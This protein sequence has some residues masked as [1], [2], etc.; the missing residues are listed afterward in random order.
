[1]ELARKTARLDDGVRREPVQ[2]SG[3][4]LVPQAGGGVR[5][6]YLPD[7]GGVQG[8]AAPSLAHDRHRGVTRHAVEVEGTSAVAD[9]EVHRRQGGAVEVV[10]ER[11]GDLTQARL[12][13]GE[14][15]QVPH[16]PSDDI[17]AAAG[18]PQRA[19]G[20]QLRD[21]TMRRGQRQARALR[22]FG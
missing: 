11:R 6:Q 16:P 4:H 2:G 8:K 17:A 7:P 5:E 21:E 15:A 12:H 9:G 18:A 14:Q 20:R 19:P 1:V 22:D 10:Q 13:G 3:E